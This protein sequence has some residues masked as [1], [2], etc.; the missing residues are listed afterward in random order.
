MTEKAREELFSD[1]E[2]LRAMLDSI[3]DHMSMIDKDLNIL[4]ANGVAKEIFGEDIIGKKCYKVYH[5][6]EE[7]CEPYP[8]IALKAF[9]DGKVHEHDT[10]VIDKNGKTIYFHCTAN[11]ALKDE[12]GKPQAVLEISRDITENKKAEEELK[13]RFHQLE[14]FHKATVD[15]ELKMKQL[16]GK[17]AELEAKLEKR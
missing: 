14:V 10:Q 12:E 11:V 16:E 9:Q 17:I 13:K 4:W 15:R 7:P 5:G 3:G 8:C 2:V 1:A 6:R